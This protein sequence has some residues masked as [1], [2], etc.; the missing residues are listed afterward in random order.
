MNRTFKDNEG[1]VWTPKVTLYEAARIKRN[2]NIHIEDFDDIQRMVQDP[3][4]LCDTLFIVCE[5]E[6]VRKGVSAENFGRSLFGDAI[7]AAREALLTAVSDFFSD[8]R[9][10]TAFM[11]CMET[12]NEESDKT[13]DKIMETL[14]ATKE[15]IREE[16]EVFRRKLMEEVE[17]Q[18]KNKKKSSTSNSGKTF[19]A[20]PES[21]EE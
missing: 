19:G 13:I 15:S 21:S 9:A 4:L 14:G 20:S 18:K 2:C 11:E 17:K 12:L 6:A 16:G 10:R 3:M 1:R 5:D 8:P 7:K